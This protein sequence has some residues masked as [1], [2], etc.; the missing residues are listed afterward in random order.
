MRTGSWNC[1]Q[2]QQIWIG[3][4]QRWF[5]IFNCS[6]QHRIT[7]FEAA[8]QN[9]KTKTEKL[10]FRIPS[11]HFRSI[12]S[13]AYQSS[14]F[15]SCRLASPNAS[16][17]ATISRGGNSSN[18]VWHSAIFRSTSTH[19]WRARALFALSFNVSPDA[20]LIVNVRESSSLGQT[21]APARCS[22]EQATA[23]N[24]SLY[25]NRYNSN[26]LVITFI[27]LHTCHR[28]GV[29]PIEFGGAASSVLLS[30]M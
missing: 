7:V 10:S 13:K 23:F 30:Q 26:D 29:L 6:C 19:S 24:Y 3:W 17:A 28:G 14:V 9:E 15:C 12:W 21:T 11:S 8:K 20:Q 27:D 18:C 25:D 4:I 5:S 22:C 2:Q 1:F 16:E